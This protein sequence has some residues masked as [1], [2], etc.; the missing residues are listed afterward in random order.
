VLQFRSAEDPA[1]PR[2]GGLRPG[3]VRGQRASAA[4]LALR[5]RADA[6]PRQRPGAHH[7]QAT[8]CAQITNLAFPAGLAQNLYLQLTLREGAPPPPGTCTIINDVPQ[9]WPGAGG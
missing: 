4:L 9:S 1:A 7:R 3:A 6:A 8:A 2:T 5:T